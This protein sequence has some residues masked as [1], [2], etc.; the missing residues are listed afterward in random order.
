M[1]RLLDL[2]FSG[3]EALPTYLLVCVSGGKERLFS[4]L[5][6]VEWVV[7]PTILGSHDQTVDFQK[8]LTQP[9]P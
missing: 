2:S 8:W 3:P 5:S 7:V 1:I 4:W 9:T 6:F